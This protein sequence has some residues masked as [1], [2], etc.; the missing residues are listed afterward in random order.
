MYAVQSFR[1]EKKKSK[2]WLKKS[3][4]AL[5]LKCQWMQISD[6]NCI[7]ISC[8]KVSQENQGWG[9]GEREE[10]QAREG[11]L[12][13]GEC[14]DDDEANLPCQKTGEDRRLGTTTLGELRWDCS[15][16]SAGRQ[17]PKWGRGRVIPQLPE[18]PGDGVRAPLLVWTGSRGGL[19]PL[20]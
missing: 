14:Y 17:E 15:W 16:W 19:L 3:K 10:G 7:F 1:P 11:Q 9:E 20:R 4:I 5:I 2:K 6:H 18:H 12:L 13:L 8:S